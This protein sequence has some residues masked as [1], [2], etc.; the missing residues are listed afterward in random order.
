MMTPRERIIVMLRGGRPDRIPFTAFDR[1]LL[2]G[3]KEREAR[4]RGLALICYRPCY[5]EAFMNVEVVTRSGSNTLIKTYNTPVGSVSEVFSHGVGYGLAGYGRDWQ[6]VVPRRKEFLVKRLEDYEVLKFMVE[7]LH[8]EPYYYAVE[9]QT[10]RLGEDGIVV[11]TLPYSPMQR[12]L[13]EFVDW[14]RFYIDLARN[15][16]KVEEIYNILEEKYEKE[17]FP[18]AAQSPSEVVWYGDNIDSILVNP[19]LF[20]RYYLPSYARCAETLHSKG[21]VLNVHMDGRLKALA[22]LIS[23]S[24]IDIVEAFT[25]PPMGDISTDEALSM[26]RDK[27]IWINFPSTVSTL[28]GPSPQKV[29]EYLIGLLESIMPGDRVMLIVST[30]NR[31]PDENLM[32]MVEVMEKATLPLTEDTIAGMRS[33]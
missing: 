1:H 33:V 31:V 7:N 16:E 23:E 20:E 26:W 4:N 2:Q 6:G 15:R 3:E 21:K 18:I 10:K 14:K 19:Q 27:H 9:D 13:I 32:A 29:K 17:L 22:R 8:Y 30:E 25:P 12:M 5:T 24:K 11:S 28:M